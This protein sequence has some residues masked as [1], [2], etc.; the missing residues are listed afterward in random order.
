[1]A[2]KHPILALVLSLGLVVIASSV[3]P[4]LFGIW[5]DRRFET[6][7]WLTLAGVLVG[8]TAAIAGI[9]RIVQRRYAELERRHRGDDST[10]DLSQG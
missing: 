5:A 6:A 4:L 7:P 3:A 2:R 9:W 10:R 1:M 8:V